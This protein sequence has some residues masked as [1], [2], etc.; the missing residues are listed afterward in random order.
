MEV[1]DREIKVSLAC[2]PSGYT[3]SF[4]LKQSEHGIKT[5]P[6]SRFSLDQLANLHF[7]FTSVPRCTPM[8]D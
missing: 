5:V 6:T 7:H 4:V 3:I 8:T 1:G 2:Q